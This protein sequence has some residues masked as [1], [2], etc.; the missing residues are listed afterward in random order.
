MSTEGLS[1]GQATSDAAI[2]ASQELMT[3][4]KANYL[5]TKAKESGYE[6]GRQEA[7]MALQMQMGSTQQQ[8]QAVTSGMSEAQILD[9]IEKKADEK[10]GTKLQA[11]QTEQ[12]NQNVARQIV[13]QYMEQVEQ[14][15][16]GYDDFD[17]VTGAFNL[18][19]SPSMVALMT[20]IPNGADVM[21]EF[22][23]HPTKFSDIES[24]V[25]KGH[26]VAAERAIKKLSDSIAENKKGKA[27][28]AEAKTS[29][30]L[31]QLKPSTGQVDGKELSQSAMKAAIR[32]LKKY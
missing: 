4:D 16:K 14:G 22:G 31:N 11:M 21:Y 23:Q 26:K 32:S 1:Q 24:L 2:S 27:K 12:A 13:S 20:T 29:E 28:V 6:K 9:L 8:T 3:Q 19:N 17:E 18:S 15:R 5:I 10:I 30:P 25:D 7:M